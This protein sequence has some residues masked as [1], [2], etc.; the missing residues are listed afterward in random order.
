MERRTVL[1]G[2]ASLGALGLA[3]GMPGLL[4]AAATAF[5]DDTVPALA[6]A[7]AAAAWQAPDTTLPPSLEIG[8]DQYRDLRFDPA[9]AP[10]R[11]ERLPFQVQ[12]FHRGFLFRPRVDVH[13]VQDGQ[14]REWHYAPSLFDFG[15]QP[16]PAADSDLGFAG[17]RVHAPLNGTHF[18]EL[19]SFL[20]ASYFRALAKGQV[21]GLSA[22]G[23][24][25]GSGDPGDEEF[26]AFRAFWLETPRAGADA[27]V[28]HALLDSPSVAGA[29]RFVV[30]PGVETVMD[31]Q[32]RLY[33]RVALARAGIAPLTSMFEFDAADRA[34]VDDYRGAVHD[35]DGL[36]LWPRDGAPAWRPL[37]NPHHLSLESFALPRP[38]GFGLMQR[39]RRFEDY[40]DAEARYQD[41]PSAWVEPVGDWG[42][43]AVVL[44]ELPTVDEYHDN[45][46]AFWRP[47]AP[48][49][50]GREHRFDYRL[51]WCNDH[52]WQ[53]ALALVAATRA[54]VAPRAGAR[55]VVVD[56][57]GGE[58]AGIDATQAKNLPA[59][60]TASAGRVENP[61]AYPMA[62]GD[63]RLAFE[64][65]PP[66]GDATLQARITGRDGAAITETWRW[67]WTP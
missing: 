23:L 4:S 5:D 25:L 3:G 27:V 59:D 54:G 44:L 47:A 10:W 61:V 2:M 65:F 37:R 18:D 45:I 31:V 6:R 60:V 57:R 43:G 20:G 15:P 63:W 34:G 17:L 55:L 32:A 9:Q 29:F 56:F 62:N 14:A 21:Y 49:A 39:K 52:R 30:R 38:R 36:A 35:S 58:L 50:A 28:V 12:A 11:R 22:R 42:D 16:K 66:A 48:L 46:V 33:P 51:H 26:P 19:V 8:Y 53:P 64:Y 13:L 40:S 67:R 41:R 24:A 1:R 7:L